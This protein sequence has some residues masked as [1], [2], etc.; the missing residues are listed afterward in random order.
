MAMSAE[1]T[2]PETEYDAFISYSRRDMVFARALEKALEGY[3]P[4]RDL[5]LSQRRVRVLR[6]ETDFTGTD[7]ADAIRRHPAAARRLIVLC[8]PAARALRRRGGAPVRRAA[9][10][11]CR[12]SPARCRPAEQ[13]GRPR[14]GIGTCVAGRTVPPHGDAAGHRLP[15]LRRRQAAPRPGAPTRP[16][17][18]SC[19]P[20]C[21]ACPGA[22]SNRGRSGAR[23]GCA[24]S[25]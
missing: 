22:K 24:A 17:G 25:G 13:R 8:S 5:P 14:P 23:R 7:Y 11:R 9:R 15:G 18:S 3:R 16:P 20:T 6:D 12:H 19:W 10:C 1:D 2:T 21:T 4:P